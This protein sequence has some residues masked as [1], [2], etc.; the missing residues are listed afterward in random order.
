MIVLK[1]EIE[2]SELA[3]NTRIYFPLCFQNE[4]FK[5]AHSL[6]EQQQLTIKKNR[7]KAVR[8]YV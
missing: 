4:G 5:A 2:V 7:V 3:E 8:M 1:Q 6:K